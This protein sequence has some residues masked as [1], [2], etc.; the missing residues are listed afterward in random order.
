MR[1]HKLSNAAAAL[2]L[3]SRKF[4]R[5]GPLPI[6]TGAHAPRRAQARDMSIWKLS[7]SFRYRSCGK[8]HY[9]PPVRMIKLTKE[10]DYA[11]VGASD[12]ER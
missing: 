5:H 4:R 11:Q 3:S 1:R 8:R 9:K 2:V 12:E 7:R 6:H 10:G